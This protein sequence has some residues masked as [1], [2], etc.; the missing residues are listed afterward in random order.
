MSLRYEQ[1]EA[2]HNMDHYKKIYGVDLAY[3]LQEGLRA[4]YISSSGFV[5]SELNPKSGGYLLNST[6]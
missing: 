4:D 6:I 5:V 3:E 1:L 2:K